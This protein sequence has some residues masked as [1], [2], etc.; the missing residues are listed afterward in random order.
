MDGVVLEGIGLLLSVGGAVVQKSLRHQ[1]SVFRGNPVVQVRLEIGARRLGRRH[2]LLGL[3]T[4]HWVPSSCLPEH[5]Y[6]D[7][8]AQRAG[9]LLAARC[10]GLPSGVGAGAGIAGGG[11]AV[12][13]RATRFQQAALNGCRATLTIPRLGFQALAAANSNHGADHN[14]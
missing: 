6:S 12:R 13:R 5:I 14:K 9:I 2:V 3:S 10:H 4:R 11:H 1:H 7:L 8:C